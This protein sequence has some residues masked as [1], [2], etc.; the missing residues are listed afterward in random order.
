MTNLDEV[1]NKFYDDPDFVI[2]AAPGQTNLSSSGT[3][4]PEWTQNTKPGKE[5]LDLK[6]LGSA[7][8]MDSSF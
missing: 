7:K 3:S 8:A 5:W 4:M 2:S 6:V 1:K